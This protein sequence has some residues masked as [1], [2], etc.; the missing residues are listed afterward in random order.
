MHGVEFPK[1]PIIML[2]NKK[3]LVNLL[4]VHKRNYKKVTGPRKRDHDM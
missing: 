4:P 3:K 2:Y 1:N